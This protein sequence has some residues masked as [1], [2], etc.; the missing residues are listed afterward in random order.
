MGT[1]GNN[2]IP[3]SKS[4]YHDLVA[5]ILGSISIILLVTL[6]MHIGQ[7]AANY[8]FYKGPTIFPLIVLSI[9]AISSLPAI[10]R[11]IRPNIDSSW[12]LDNMGWPQKPVITLIIL[13]V[14]FIFGIIGIGVEVSVFLYLLISYFMLGYRNYRVSLLLPLVYTA[15]LIL[16]FK[17]FLRIWFP[18]P[19]ILGF[20]GV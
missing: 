4:R 19:L 7:P 3:D 5:A 13:V 12:N 8:P 18:E 16:I 6:K 11:L 10:Y 2:K 15:I 14:F 1:E 17:Y 9:M 20:L